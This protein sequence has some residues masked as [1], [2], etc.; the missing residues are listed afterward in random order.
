MT[1]PKTA[2][3]FIFYFA[4]QQ[5]IKFSICFLI[6]IAFAFN[7][8]FFP[9]FLKHIVNTLA[10][11]QY[12]S[13][14]AIFYAL[15]GLLILIVASWAIMEV[16]QRLQGFILTS[17]LPRYRADIRTTVF[18]YVLGHSHS[19]FANHFAGN[20]AKKLNDLPNSCQTMLEIIC[21]QFVT[22]FSG[23]TIVVVMMWHTQPILAVIVL[24]WLCVHLGLTL[25]FVRYGDL[26]WTRHSEASSTLGGKIVD[27]LT[28][29]MNVKLFARRQYEM[30]YLAPY[31]QD[32][33]CKSKKALL[34][35]EF[36]RMGLGLNGLFL[37]FASVFTLVYGYGHHWITLGDF[38]QV[39]MQ[40]FW[41]LGF[42]W[43][44]SYQLTLYVRESGVINDA[45]SLVRKPHELIDSTA[46]TTLKVNRGEISWRA[47]C[48][49][50]PKGSSVFQQLSV[51]IP[52]GQK[53]GLVGFS[54][55]GKSTFVN[56][57]LRFYDVH[58]GSIHI[59]GQN[60]AEVTQDSLRE[61]IAMIPQ[62][63]S[64]FHRTLMENIRYGRLDATD[65]EVIAAAKLAH[66]DEFI[67]H[68][69]EGYHSLVGE[70]GIKLS[71]GQ[72]QRIAIARAILK[73]APILILDEATSSLD[74]V[75][76]KLI[77][78][79][80][81]QLMQHRTTLVV[82]HRLS[83]LADM[84]RILVFQGGEII[85]DGA[86]TELLAQKGHFAMLWHSQHGGFLPEKGSVWGEPL[87]V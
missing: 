7:E 15:K 49:G 56:L 85:E 53:I 8:T 54:G 67:Q 30:R 58:A 21:L 62:D 12:A 29:M 79:S 55:S 28:N 66:C 41:I 20:I 68:L 47:V 83:T 46:A 74:S 82:A 19:Y 50:Y 45:L 61:S 31:Q 16:F 13:T 4:K 35:I 69:P 3:P 34:H 10:T 1:F 64:L 81:Q 87:R 76:E 51:E 27:T 80:L 86:M 22:A 37:I 44:I 23:S 73:D 48:F 25:L 70:R 43:Y 32:E 60:I 6:A 5:W 40:I 72:R 42:I 24:A 78:Q 17:A 75:T 33:L 9:F 2:L 39:G 14:A 18:E 11:H 77:Q 65:E 84:D 59:D 71:G 36:L 63:P 38:T 26:L 57:L 52:A